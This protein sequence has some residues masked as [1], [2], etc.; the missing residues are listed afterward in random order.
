MNHLKNVT[1]VGAAGSDFDGISQ[2]DCT[3]SAVSGRLSPDGGLTVRTISLDHEIDCGALPEPD[4]IKIDAEGGEL[5][6]LKGAHCVLARRH[7]T[8]SIET[9]QWLPE[10][11]TV[12]KDCIRFLYQLGYTL[13]EPDPTDRDS[14]SH[15]CAPSYVSRGV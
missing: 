10:F 3:G 8:L 1:V 14:D 2:F 9:H 13:E 4:Y 12:R 6:V 5:K 15:L 11:A 7:S